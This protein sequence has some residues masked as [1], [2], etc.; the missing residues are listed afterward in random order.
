[1]NKD[2]TSCLGYQ[3]ITSLS[4]ATGLTVPTVTPEG[5]STLPTHAMIICETN[6]VRWRDDGVNPTASVGMLMQANSCMMYDGD[7]KK[8]RFIQTGAAATIS[9]SYYK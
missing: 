1:M 4:S 9:V 6:P 2:I 3:Q 8:I 5:L 7:L